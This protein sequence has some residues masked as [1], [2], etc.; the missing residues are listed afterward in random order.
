MYQ[1][2]NADLAAAVGDN[3]Y[4]FEFSYRGGTNQNDGYLNNTPGGLF[5]FAGDKQDFPFVSLA[6]QTV[7]DEVEEEVE[8]EI[9]DLDFSM[10]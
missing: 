9:D 7:I 2:V 8:E 3:I 10:F 5:L 6:D 4:K 1:L